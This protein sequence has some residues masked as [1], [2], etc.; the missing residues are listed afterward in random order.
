ML[1]T[2]VYMFGRVDIGGHAD[3]VG[4]VDLVNVVDL[5]LS[6]SSW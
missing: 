5:L 3:M 2:C 6:C 4:L 1:C